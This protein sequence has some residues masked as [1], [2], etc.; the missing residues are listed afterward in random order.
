[1]KIKYPLL[2]GAAWGLAAL[3][4]IASVSLRAEALDNWHVRTSPS[5]GNLAAVTYGSGLFVAVGG[6]DYPVE[7]DFI[8]T[9][10][11][12]VTWTDHS[13]GTTNRL[14][15]VAHGNKT[16]VALGRFS[17]GILVPDCATIVTS[18]NGV[19][20]V[21]Q[22]LYPSNTLTAV[23]YANGVFVAVG[24][25]GM[26]L[27]SSNGLSWSYQRVPGLY[28]DFI[29][30][31]FGNG[32]FAAVTRGTS[33][34]SSDGYNWTKRGDSQANYA[35]AY[36]N[37]LFVTTYRFDGAPPATEFSVSSDAEHWT[38]QSFLSGYFLGPGL[39]Y[40]NGIFV[41]LGDSPGVI[42]WLDANA[43]PIGRRTLGNFYLRGVSYGRGTF[44]A[45]GDGGAIVQSD[46]LP[47]ARLRPGSLDA[48]GLA[49]SI[50]GEDGL[51]YRLQASAELPSTNWTDLLTFTNTQP[52][53]NFVD[54]AATNFT[55]RFYRVVSP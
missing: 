46:P 42:A 18:T 40:G 44:V 27:T 35:I 16:F 49:L 23:T 26:I 32:F 14:V 7:R 41:A 10:P 17:R 25:D 31:I 37:G 52:E 8:L 19:E 51:R 30:V 39:I 4:C 45:V 12:G 54:T 6:S 5:T 50:G 15:A 1:M 11:D 36:G 28:L 48:R 3:L 53:R 24:N 21:M 38:F 33:L 34:T 2:T 20:W 55:R 47:T 43:Q 13:S 9:S 22:G 29:G